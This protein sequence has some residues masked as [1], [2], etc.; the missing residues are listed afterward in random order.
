MS[1]KCHPYQV[2]RE[3]KYSDLPAAQLS[4]VSEVSKNR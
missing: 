1:S 4:R 2:V 3:K